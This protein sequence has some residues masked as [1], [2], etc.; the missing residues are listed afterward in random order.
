M[1]RSATRGGGPGRKD[2]DSL[3]ETIKPVLAAIDRVKTEMLQGG[4][5]KGSAP[6]GDQK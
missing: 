3:K 6:G 1:K 4:T 5:N 2:G